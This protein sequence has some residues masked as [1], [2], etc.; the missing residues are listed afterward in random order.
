M[1]ESKHH[2]N[3]FLGKQSLNSTTFLWTWIFICVLA[4]YVI[5]DGVSMRHHSSRHVS[6]SCP[7]H[8]E[9]GSKKIVCVDQDLRNI[10]FSQ[11]LTHIHLTSV[12]NPNVNN[13]TLSEAI[14][15]QE[16][17]WTGSHIIHIDSDA[18]D[19]LKQLTKLNLANNQ[20]THVN[21]FLN[22]NNLN[23]L[24][25]SYNKID[26]LPRRLFDSLENLE[27]LYL[28]HNL[29]HV[30]PFQAFAPLHNLKVL[31]LSH[32]LMVNFLDHFFKP[33]KLI[34][35]LNLSHNKIEKLA[36][37]ALADLKDL[38]H[39]DLSNNA[40]RVLTIGVFDA[41]K[42]LE[43]L[44]LANNPLS[45]FN[46][47]T[48][49]HL[50]NLKFLNLSGNN[51]T[52]ITTSMFLK[53]HN[54][55]TLVVA[56]TKI[57]KVH[58]T[59]LIG[60]KNLK[61]LIIRDNKYLKEIETYVLDDTPDLEFVDISGNILTF[62]PKSIG[63]LEK[64][65]KLDIS[66]NF[67]GCDCRMVWFES[68]ASKRLNIFET[69]LSCGPHSYP[70]DMLPTLQHLNCT[71]PMLRWKTPT[72]RYILNERVILNCKYASYPAPTIT[73]ITPTKLV[74]HSNPD[75]SVPD[76]FQKHSI[77][78]DF[79]QRP[80]KGRLQVHENG[81][82]I[83]NNIT[84]EETG[85]YVCVATTPTGNS[86]AYVTIEMNPIEMYYIQIHSCI[87]GAICAAGFLSLTLLV[88]LLRFILRK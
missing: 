86:S 88:Q 51:M 19:N 30:I 36:S 43:Y 47:D 31:D 75:P 64:L 85:T 80:Y 52:K 82:L 58:N 1:C 2:Y 76:I 87:F 25:L 46:R 23:V 13:K 70:N 20:L 50:K 7:E 61:Q 71:E 83:I 34:G 84:R 44:N 42:L 6:E 54:I 29:L 28:Q 5:C 49:Q 12:S 66:Q 79:Y 3:G 74:F 59:E 81:S 38:V 63:G 8:C 39:L 18:F 53:T 10:E 41:L 69:D 4:N 73:W 35:E 27:E 40:L 48:F 62:L 72:K 14:N 78:H 17:E 37:N 68:W 67:W 45:N 57:D 11:H 22:L 9:C 33:N 56:N 65:K 26:D 32:N 15:L 60:L 24:N 77:A 55:E 21:Y 16:L